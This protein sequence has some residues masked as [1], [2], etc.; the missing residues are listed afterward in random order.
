MNPS[1]DYGDPF[2]LRFGNPYLLPYFSD[3]I[4]ITAGYFEK[5]YNYSLS[6]GFNSLR[7]I[8]TYIRTLQADGKT[9]TTWQ[10]LSG[11]KEYEVASW[12]GLRITSLLKVNGSASY[13]YNVYSEQD[14]IC[15]LYTSRC[16]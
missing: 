7:N 4:D 16:V 3:N 9:Y 13:V 8:Y 14:K 1:I 12:G 10:N 15:L 2:N 11:R 5:Q 6:V